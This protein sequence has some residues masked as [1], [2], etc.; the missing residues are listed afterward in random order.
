MYSDFYTNHT[1]AAAALRF[2]TDT[3]CTWVLYCVTSM[4]KFYFATFT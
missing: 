4:V 1:R 2:T 3:T